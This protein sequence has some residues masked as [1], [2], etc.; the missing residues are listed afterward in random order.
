M[1]T[2]NI[3]AVAILT[4]VKTYQEKEFNIPPV[5]GISEKTIN[6]HIDLYKGYVTNVNKHYNKIKEVCEADKGDVTTASALT[7]RIPFELAG[8]CN[9]EHYFGALEGGPA[10]PTNTSKLSAS[11]KNQFGSFDSFKNAMQHTATAM[12]GV[13]WAVATHDNT[14]DAIHIYW[15]TDHELGNVNLQTI[16]AV[17]VWE[18]AY[19]LDYMPSE[20]GKYVSAYLNAVNWRVVEEKFEEGQ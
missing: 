3:R 7:R 9:H 5:E 15:I 19:L 11:V 14:R 16:L 13:G 2:E 1:Q 6:M 12:R 17:D 18:H 4:K 8:V 10:E 20:K